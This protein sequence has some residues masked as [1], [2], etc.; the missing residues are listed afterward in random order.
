[1]AEQYT[2]IMKDKKKYFSMKEIDRILK[3]CYQNDRIRDYMLILTLVRTGRRVS[4]IVGMRPYTH[5]VGLRP[6]DLFD[7]GL[8]EFDILKKGRIKKKT[9]SGK[10]ISEEKYNR[11]KLFKKP[12]R[13]LMPV[14]K[15][16]YNLLNVYTYK[17]NI[18]DYDRIFK[19]TRERVYQIINDVC[20][21]SGVRRPDNKYSPH[22]FRH[23]MAINLLKKNPK[24]PYIL[25][26]IQRLLDHSSLEMTKHYTQFTPEDIKESLDDLF[27]D[28]E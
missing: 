18:G 8:I 12:V 9:K 27:G 23:S 6:V 21:K 7:D 3:Y 22:M 14:D 20:P 26:Q 28:K 13:K 11:M 16:F 1:M 4:E 5:Y 17:N 2:N 25:I 24:N 19:L 15:K 10:P